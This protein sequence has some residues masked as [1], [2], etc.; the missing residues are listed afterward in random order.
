MMYVGALPGE[1]HGVSHPS[2]CTEGPYLAQ[3][4]NGKA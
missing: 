3:S 1:R 2:F 4:F